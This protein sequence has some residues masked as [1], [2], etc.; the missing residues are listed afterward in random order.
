[1]MQTYNAATLN[2]NG[3]T[4]HTRIK[5]LEDLLWTQDIDIALLQEVT[6]PRL[7]VTRQYAQYINVGTGKRGTA[8]LA[9]DG[10]ILTD[11]RC[12]PS[13]RGITAR[14]NGISLI[15][16][17]APSGSEKKQERESFY[18]TEVPYLLPGHNMEIIL[19]GDFNCVLSPSDATGQK[20]YSRALD[21]LVTGLK[22]HDTGEQNPVR[23]SYT[24]YTPRGAS[25]IDRIYISNNLQQR[26]QGTSTVVA[27]FTDH[28]A[29]RIRMA[30]SDPIPTRGIG[31]WKIN[32]SVL[33]EGAFGEYCS[34]NGKSGGP[35][36]NIT[37]PRYCGGRDT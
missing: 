18:N 3:I 12:L 1:M 33:K 30:S 10:I 28:L 25:R 16:I 20:N 13:G 37:P 36:G 32:I 4:N 31:Q 14:Y 24:H 2:I 9:K 19:A 6:C 22:L 5:I 15:N 27:A 34:T 21:K 26:K 7:D 11:I 8:I 17:Y 23:T 29:I 35:T